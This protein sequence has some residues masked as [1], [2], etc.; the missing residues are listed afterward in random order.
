MCVTSALGLLF[1]AQAVM[2]ADA[3]VYK[4]P[5]SCDEDC[6]AAAALVAQMAGLN[7]VFVG[8]T[9]SNPK[10]FANAVVW[11]QPGGESRTVGRNM[12]EELKNEIRSFVHGGGAYVGFCAGGFYATERIGELKDPGLG[13]IPGSTALYEKI[14]TDAG[15]LEL[16]WAGKPRGLY[17][18]G[19]PAFYPPTDG[20]APAE[21]MA[22][23]PDG[24][25]AAV[26]A[27]YGSGRVY[28][29]GVHP[30]APQWWRDYY[31]L[32]DPDGLDYD[33][34]VGMIRW[35]ARLPGGKHHH[36]W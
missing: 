14:D 12:S 35:A 29:T 15:L 3:L 34:A 13:L 4:G 23:Y 2:A 18:E 22:T 11:I 1:S 10:L 5:G 20:S 32:Q 6:S 7:P 9:D 24:T 28:V 25:A 30:E 33:L 26:R 31:K 27:A 17:W 16:N 21:V 8:P 36:G 19:G